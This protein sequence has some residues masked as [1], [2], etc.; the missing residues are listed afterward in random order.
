VATCTAKIG[1]VSETAL[2]E[3]FA[4]VP[5]CAD[6]GA[7]ASIGPSIEAATAVSHSGWTAMT[8]SEGTS[9]ISSNADCSAPRDCVC[10]CGATDWAITT[11]AARTSVTCVSGEP[12]AALCC[13]T[14]CRASPCDEGAPA[15]TD[16]LA[17][18]T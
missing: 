1:V 11:C 17:S 5:G 10:P 4:T 9:E 8:D 7:L 13:S 16:T 15:S 14:D 3:R 18:S 12:G 2:P 6:L